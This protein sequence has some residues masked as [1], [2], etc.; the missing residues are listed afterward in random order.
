MGSLARK[1]L[2]EIEMYLYLLLLISPNFGM[3]S[4][5]LIDIGAGFFPKSNLRESRQLAFPSS[6]VINARGVNINL[7]DALPNFTESSQAILEDRRLFH[8][9][10]GNLDEAEKNIIA[11]SEELRNY[12][13]EGIDIQDNYFPEYNKAKQYLRESRQDLWLLADRTVKEVR[14]LKALLEALDDSKDLGLLELTLDQ[15]KNLMNETLKILEEALGKYNKAQRIFE[16]L[17][18][19]VKKQGENLR[20]VLEAVT[21]DTN[22]EQER[23][24]L[25]SK[26]C[27][28]ADW[29]TFGLCSPIHE[30]VNSG[31]LERVTEM[32]E[33]MESITSRWKKSGDKLDE[34]VKDAIGILTKEIELINGW[35]NDAEIIKREIH[36][37]TIKNLK[38]Y[39]A[40]RDNFITGLDNLE[41]SAQNFLDHPVEIF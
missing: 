2:G 26:R 3:P 32:L 25:I 5:P 34:F 17:K 13:I 23:H 38:K 12:N 33:K 6:T 15:M 1:K 21:D 41:N 39:T 30:A 29:F 40:I 35:K 28:I 20:T 10:A 14:V 9:V 27:A 19:S 18:S 36:D 31:K 37:R 7:F 16:N 4:S 8:F 22:Q 11:L 24:D